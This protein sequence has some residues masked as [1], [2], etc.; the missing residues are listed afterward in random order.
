M[1]CSGRDRGSGMP[2]ESDAALWQQAIDAANAE[3]L[4]VD[5]E[6]RQLKSR[7]RKLQ[8]ALRVFLTNKRDGIAW[9]RQEDEDAA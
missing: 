3:L 4:T 6:I 1:A 7:R 8:F 9:P 2:R 5:K